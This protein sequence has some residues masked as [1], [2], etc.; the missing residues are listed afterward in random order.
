MLLIIPKISHEC[1]GQ[2]IFSFSVSINDLLS[3]Y[4]AIQKLTYTNV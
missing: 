3:V 2:L 1:S 4:W